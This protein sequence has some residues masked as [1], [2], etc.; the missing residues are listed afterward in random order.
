MGTGITDKCSLERRE[1]RA[2]KRYPALLPV[3]V[4]AV[5]QRCC[6]ARSRDISTGGVYL[7]VEADQMAAD[8]HVQLTLFLPRELIGGAGV[9]M[10]AF[11][12]IIR[13]D[14]LSEDESR[15]MGVA[16]AFETYDFIPMTSP[17]C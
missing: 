5:S 17:S 13:V 8:T 15:R 9:L 11:G 7:F 16:V 1:R 3:V 2:T 12:T 6:S 10:R 4:Q 14:T